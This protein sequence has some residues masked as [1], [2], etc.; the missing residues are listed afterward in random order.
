METRT[1]DDSAGGVASRQAS[2]SLTYMLLEVL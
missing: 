1:N 2:T